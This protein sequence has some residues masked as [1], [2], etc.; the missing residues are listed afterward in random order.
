MVE[1]EKFLINDLV[2]FSTEKKSL[3][4]L[5]DTGNTVSLNGPASE[6]LTLLLKKNG[7][8]IDQKEFFHEV[9]ESKGQYVTTNTFYQNI[10]VLRK[11]MKAVG[12]N[13]EIIKTLP[14]LGIKFTGKVEM[15]SAEHEL[16]NPSENSQADIDVSKEIEITISPNNNKR[17]TIGLI[18]LLFIAFSILVFTIMDNLKY[19]TNYLSLYESIG[20]INQCLVKAKG[21]DTTSYKSELISLFNQSGLIC[22][23]G[24]TAYITPNSLKNKGSIIIC[25]PENNLESCITYSFTESHHE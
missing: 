12:I 20:E 10:S 9:W 17:N 23:K 7:K 19:K 15:I 2:V 1:M 8:V 13:D 5:N 21:S 22:N 24:Q 18:T 25:N 14:K 6:C 4:P 11:A 16:Y 3:I